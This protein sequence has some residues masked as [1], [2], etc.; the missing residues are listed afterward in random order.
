MKYVTSIFVALLLIWMAIGNQPRKTSSAMLP[1]TFGH[2]DHTTV[3]CVSCHHN[4]IDDTGQGL[5]FDCHVN[6]ADL[7]DLL[8]DQFHSLCRDCHV[9]KQSHADDGGPTR[10]CLE[11]HQPDD[12][13]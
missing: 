6:D 13:P 5:C 8:E 12:R 10:V 7:R 2:I 9:D 11:C 1:I 4:F 3:N